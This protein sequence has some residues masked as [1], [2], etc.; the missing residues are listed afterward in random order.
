MNWIYHRN[1][2]EKQ[3]LLY[4]DFLP[5]LSDEMQGYNAK[6]IEKQRFKLLDEIQFLKL[7]IQR[8]DR[9]TIF[10]ATEQ[11][12]FKTTKKLSIISKE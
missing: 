9:M 6:E 7:Q 10:R 2:I 1:K 4:I 12:K 5:F 11:V 8:V 3:M